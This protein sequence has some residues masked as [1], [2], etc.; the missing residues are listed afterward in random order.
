LERIF[1]PFE[2]GHGDVAL[3]QPGTGL[4]L[5]ITR[6]LAQVMGGDVAVTSTPGQGSVFKLRLLLA[7]PG[8]A[9]AATARQRLI[10]G[11]EGRRRTV[12]VIDDDPLQLAVLQDLLRP[13]GFNVF[14]AANGPDGIDL[15]LR[16]TPDLVLL[17]IQMPGMSGWEV[18]ARL[19]AIAADT[20]GDG[21]APKVLLVSANAHEF[22]IGGDGKADHHGFVVKPVEL[23]LLLDA[24][25][26]QLGLTWTGD[27]AAAGTEALPAA[28]LTAAA[29]SLAE[30]RRLGQVGH[31]RGIEAALAA[32]EADVPAS[33][34]LVE[35]LRGHVRAFDLGGYLR[36]LDNH[37]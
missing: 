36:L 3:A 27:V 18:A 25:A 26:G 23:E 24:I 21:A 20:A 4:G 35:Q 14:A 34:P 16:C 13:L 37:G 1:E 32:L 29:V 11:Y 5:A 31:V 9:V 8:E 2:R 17:D 30:L 7:E 12:L 19:R 15:A 28:D 6:V 10:G 22:A 33:R